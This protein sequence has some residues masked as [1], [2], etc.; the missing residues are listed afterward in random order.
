MEKKDSGMVSK[1]LACVSM[2]IILLN[3]ELGNTSF[4]L[5]ISFVRE[6]CI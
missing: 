2:W 4:S 6:G 3:T 1:F 5:F